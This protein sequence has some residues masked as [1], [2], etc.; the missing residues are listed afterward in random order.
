MRDKIALIMEETGCERAEA[1]L[2]LEAC[3]YEVSDALQTIARRLRRLS[4]VKA[5]FVFPGNLQYGLLLFVVDLKTGVLA[6]LRTV[7]SFNPAIYA[8]PLDGDW[9]EFE[10]HIFRCRLWEGSLQAETLELE[11]FLSRHWRGVDAEILRQISERK[12]PQVAAEIS[13]LLNEYFKGPT[14]MLKVK[15]DTID[16]GQFK[17]LKAHGQNDSEGRSSASARTRSSQEEPLILAVSIEK[18]SP[19]RAQEI[20][21]G[22]AAGYPAVAVRASDL[23]V[24]D[25]VRVRIVD[26]RD[27]ATYLA[28]VFG[29][30]LE[31]G[32]AS[33]MVPVE[34]VETVPG[35]RVLVRVRFSIGACG[36][37]VET[38][39]ES[40]LVVRA[41][42]KNQEKSSWWRRLIGK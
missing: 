11:S 23:R 1:E 38:A 40:L 32:E 28:K 20:P 42:G 27:I 4:V 8:A 30:Y 35:G 29:A 41:A 25:I 26:E 24:G 37:A 34:A 6:R 36:D 14:A 22:L 17:S 12:T 31:Q 19:D 39:Q 18:E 3:G 15:K 9:F 21:A 10:K 33:I 5:K 16:L 2:A 13:E 7:V